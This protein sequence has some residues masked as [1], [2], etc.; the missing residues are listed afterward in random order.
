MEGKLSKVMDCDD[1]IG[2]HRGVKGELG[3][4]LGGKGKRVVYSRRGK[5][6]WFSVDWLVHTHGSKDTRV[7]ASLVFDVFSMGVAAFISGGDEEGVIV[8]GIIGVQPESL[9]EHFGRR[10]RRGRDVNRRG[11]GSRGNRRG[12]RGCKPRVSDRKNKNV[13]RG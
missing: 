8:S 12:M 3:A 2:S 10:R 4:L 1:N 7:R 9:E 6:E 13:A 5:A 11:R